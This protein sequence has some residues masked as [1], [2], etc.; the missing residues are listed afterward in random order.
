MDPV[1]PEMTEEEAA[2]ILGGQ[3]NLWS[4]LIY[5]GKIAEYMIF[6]RLCAV[7][8]ALW[9]PRENKDFDD[10]SRRL[11]VHQ[12]RLDRLGL[13]QYRGPLR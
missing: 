10:F 7:A 3:C 11:T 13:L 5:A 9:T 1:T 4:E 12:Q 8:E 2:R 6:P